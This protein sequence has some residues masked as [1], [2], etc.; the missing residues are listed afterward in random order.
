MMEWSDPLEL[1]EDELAAAR[2]LDGDRKLVDHPKPTSWTLS[3]EDIRARLSLIGPIV[4]RLMEAVPH[5]YTHADRQ[6][7]EAACRSLTQ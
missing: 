3:I 7:V 4:R 6:L 1:S 5:H 2:C